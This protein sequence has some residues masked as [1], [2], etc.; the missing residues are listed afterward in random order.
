MADDGETNVETMLLRIASKSDVDA[1]LNLVDEGVDV[2]QPFSDGR[3]IAH[4]AAL[5]GS[6]PILRCLYALNDDS[7]NPKTYHMS[8]L[9]VALNLED[10]RT[11]RYLEQLGAQVEVPRVLPAVQEDPTNFII[12]QYDP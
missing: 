11:V 3:T 2:F 1:L 5:F 4:M 7:F 9:K 10:A 8:P 6:I 12:E